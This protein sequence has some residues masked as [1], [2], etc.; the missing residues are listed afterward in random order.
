MFFQLR[1][2]ID[3]ILPLLESAKERKDLVPVACVSDQVSN[4]SLDL[5]AR[6]YSLKIDF[7]INAY[8]KI[9]SGKRPRLRDADALVSAS[10]S[11]ANPH[12]AAHM[13]TKRA[14]Q[15]G[16]RTYTL[17]H[18]FEN[19]GLTYFDQVHTVE[20]IRFESQKIFIWGPIERL[21]KDVP[22]ETKR[23]CVPVGCCKDVTNNPAHLLRP[24]K[25][26]YLV[27]I[28]ENLHWHRYDDDYRNRFL[29]DLEGTA[30]RFQ[31]TTF[32]VKPHPAGRWLTHRYKGTL[33][34]GD[35]ILVAYLE[36]PKWKAYTGQ[37]LVGLADAI[38]TTPSTV[39]LDAARANR[40][41]AVVGY[42]LDLHAYEPLPTILSTRDWNSFLERLRVPEKH[43][44][45]EAA[46]ASFSKR[47]LLAG[48]ASSRI[49]DYISA[50]ISASRL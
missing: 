40:P 8:D 16:L 14:N 20:N 30:R 50:D 23:K 28:F 48:D 34:S 32:L 26:K 27:A 49:L 7:E 38:I 24:G 5:L 36:D 47:V 4:Q 11:T 19:I 18:G 31:D 15:A 17:Q 29:S 10:E 2:D 35:N 21:H 9:A 13:L 6:L 33:P 41:V 43:Y 3:L 44:E 25:R 46:V 22:E 1:M 45:I 37:A 39:A 12:R 42:N